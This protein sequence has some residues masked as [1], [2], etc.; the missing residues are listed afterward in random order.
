MTCGNA[1]SVCA[2]GILCVGLAFSLAD[3]L[4]PFPCRGA[5]D[6]S[7]RKPATYFSQGQAI[8]NP[9]DS[10]GTRQQAVHDFLV[11]AITQ[12]MGSFISP[13]IMGGNF[14]D[15]EDGIL[16]KPE[17]YVETYQVFSENPSN[18]FYRITGQVTIVVDDLKRD[19]LQMGIPLKGMAAGIP[20]RGREEERADGPVTREERE[21]PQRQGRSRGVILTKR[22]VFWAVTERWGE[23][24]IL[25]RD[26]HE[27]RALFLQ[28][29]LQE[30]QDY[31]W[32]V[33]FPES[34]ALAID[35]GGNV[36]MAQVVS[37][38]RSLG[39]SMAVSGTV[40]LGRQS[41]QEGASVEASLRVFEV[42][43]GKALG[44]IRKTY[45]IGTATDQ[46]GA[47]ELA[48]LVVPQLDRMIREASGGGS[49]ATAGRS[50][51]LPAPEREP[52][53]EPLPHQPPRAESS[54]GENLSP[55]GGGNEPRGESE[56]V[57][58]T[59]AE[60]QFAYLEELQGLLRERSKSVEVKGIRIDGREIKMRLDGVDGQLMAS[61][62]GA[63]L[64]SGG[65]VQVIAISQEERLVTV[66]FSN[67]RVAPSE[68]R[69]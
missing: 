15:I 57:L 12:A 35:P 4:G 1:R 26:R 30:S 23:N 42:S 43:S 20:E 27:N 51:E 63:K 50:P 16:A 59:S 48:T 2:W 8:L 46:E 47:M 41:G 21:G 56:W 60:Y 13:S 25:V 17:R 66:S 7:S 65:L 58:V 64:R 54:R 11:Q 19:L 28:S 61:L 29:V 9:Q 33:I 44:E 24:W 52:R 55:S 45:G 22:E 37:A 5:T 10:N 36:S 3:F 18:G 53:Q 69:P 62:N 6:P 39:L 14:G 31:E 68:P 32:S 40:A 49:S 67:P 34:V 38:A